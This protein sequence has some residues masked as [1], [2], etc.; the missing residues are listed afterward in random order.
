MIS[1]AAGFQ[2]PITGQTFE[3]VPVGRLFY[4]F[5]ERLYV[6]GHMGGYQCGLRETEPYVPLPTAVISAPMRTQR[7]DRSLRS[8]LMRLALSSL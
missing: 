1:T 4:E 3:D 6:R 5:I 7:V 2:D 8:C